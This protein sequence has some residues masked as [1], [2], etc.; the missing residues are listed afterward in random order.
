[1]NYS[2]I[3]NSVLNSRLAIITSEE[4]IDYLVPGSVVLLNRVSSNSP[5][6]S[7]FLRRQ[8]SDLSHNEIAFSFYHPLNQLRPGVIELF[9]T[10]RE[11]LKPANDGIISIAFSRAEHRRM[12]L[13]GD[14]EY[15]F[16][17]KDLDSLGL[18]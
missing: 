13:P 11:N 9:T 5:N 10:R 7:V 3:V 1:M 4:S 16:I 8:K 18:L 2:D 15:D 17:R 6:Y 12:L 14:K